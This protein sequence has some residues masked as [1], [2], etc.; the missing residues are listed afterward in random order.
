MEVKSG[1]ES[2]WKTEAYLIFLNDSFMEKCVERGLTE[3]D[4]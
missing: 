3:K 2:G 4:Q 1:V